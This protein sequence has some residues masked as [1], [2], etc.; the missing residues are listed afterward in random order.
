[1]EISNLIIKLNEEVEKY[2]V[3]DIG[4]RYGQTGYIDF[5]NIKEVTSPIMRGVD[6]WG[7]KFIVFKLLIDGKLVLQT[8]FQRYKDNLYLWKGCGHC[9]IN[10]LLFHAY[11]DIGITQIDLFLKI[12]NNETVEITDKHNATTDYMGKKVCLYNKKL[13]KSSRI[14]ENIKNID[15]MDYI[16]QFIPNNKIFKNLPIICLL[17]YMIYI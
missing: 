8:L 10:P 1:M 13:V 3:L 14:I 4:S 7:R 15:N 11:V 16:F 9:N 17:A 6:N 2:P 12:I 5:I